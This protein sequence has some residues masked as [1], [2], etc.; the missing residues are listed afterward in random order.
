MIGD[1]KYTTEE[2]GQLFALE[3]LLAALVVLAGIAFALQATVLTP[4]TSGATEAPADATMVNSILTTAA[5]NGELQTALVNDWG[6]AGF[7]GSAGQWYTG[8][9]PSNDFGTALEQGLG[10]TVTV[11]VLI[12]HRQPMDGHQQTRFIYNGAPGD[13]AV[14]SSTTLT[15]YDRDVSNP[16]TFYAEDVSPSTELYNVLE[17]EVV[18]WQG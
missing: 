15:L 4:S 8:S 12:Y 6:G 3:G 10:P 18:A 17:V 9:Y 1:N 2:R 7:S 11:N 13:G 16:G 5:E 14:R